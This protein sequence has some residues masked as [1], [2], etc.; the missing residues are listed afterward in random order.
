MKKRI[1]GSSG[2]EVSAIGL[3]CWGMSGAY[4]AGDKKESIETIHESIDQ[5]INFIDTADIYGN[6]HNE[7]LVGE[8]LRNLRQDVILATKFGFIGGENNDLH[9]NGRPEYVKKA[10]DASLKR[11]G[12]EYIDLYYL[13]RLDKNVPVEDTVG[14]MSRL[15]E[16][17]KIRFI[18]LSEVSAG[19]LNRAVNVHPVAALQSEY[20]LTTRDIENSVIPSCRKNNVA[21]VAFSPLGRALLTLSIKNVEDLEENDFRRNIPRFQGNNFKKNLQLL[22]LITDIAENKNITPAQIALA[23]LLHRGDDII[24]IPGMKRKKYVKENIRSANVSLFQDEI[25]KLDSIF[26][27]ISGERYGKESSKFIE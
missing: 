3:G 1:L 8:A 6:G 17:G 24:P 25:E 22:A 12:T 14:A 9:V 27:N 16:K 15:V 26:N 4:G 2:L 11:L 10:C 21:I 19:T 23:W 20:S 13:H 18:G 7:I 5:G